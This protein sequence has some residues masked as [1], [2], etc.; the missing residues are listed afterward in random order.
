MLSLA[1][2]ELARR[3]VLYPGARHLPGGGLNHQPVLY[4]LAGPEVRWI[5]EPVRQ[6][7]ARLLPALVAEL[8]KHRGPA[9]VSAESLA[10]FSV[11]NGRS[12]IEA[13]GYAPEQVRVVITARDLGRLMTSV[14]QE[15]VKNG[16]TSTMADYL[17]SVARLRDADTSPFWD[18]YAL[19]RLVDRWAEIVGIS[20][21]SLVTVPQAERRE[22]LWPRFCRAIG[23]PDLPLPDRRPV[24]RQ[25]NISL[26]SSQ[27]ELLRQLNV[28][29]ETDELAHDERQRLRTRLLDAWMANPSA[30]SRELEL[31]TALATSLAEWT[32][33]DDARL[34]SRVAD[35]LVVE[36]DL[37]ELTPAPRPAGPD[38]ED[39]E[40]EPGLQ[41]AARDLL[42]LLRE[43]QPASAGR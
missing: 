3:G 29:L 38:G 39:A 23:V 15:N 20:S 10:S 28:V 24:G 8:R 7:G 32:A 18:A 37:D 13:L 19:P 5:S 40:D 9:V 27:V 12:V 36:G 30:R 6:R 41:D 26:T 42:A 22:E 33:E 11:E 4:A 25:N 2:P 1:R 16:A 35:G 14:W 31:T 43:P 17:A 21:V 34:R